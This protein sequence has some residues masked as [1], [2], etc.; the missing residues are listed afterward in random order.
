MLRKFF[1]AISF[2]F[3]SSIVHAMDSESN[4]AAALTIAQEIISNADASFKDAVVDVRMF[5]VEEPDVNPLAATVKLAAVDYYKKVINDARVPE[6]IRCQ[7]RERIV[8]ILLGCYNW[9]P[10]HRASVKKIED[11]IY[12]PLTHSPLITGHYKTLKATFNEI[13]MAQVGITPSKR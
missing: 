3:C 10:N 12:P 2:L 7:T 11:S 6:D 4:Y 9:C 1:F 13:D 8:E 5:Y